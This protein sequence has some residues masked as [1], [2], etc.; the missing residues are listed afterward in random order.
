MVPRAFIAI[1]LGFFA[2]SASASEPGSTWLPAAFNGWQ[3]VPETLKS[4][5]DPGA[6]DQADSAVLKEYGFSDYQP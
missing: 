6:V 4:G 2:L 3:V 5:S 1:I